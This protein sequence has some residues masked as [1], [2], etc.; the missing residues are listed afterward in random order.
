MCLHDN[1]AAAARKWSENLPS[2]ILPS[3]RVSRLRVS[4][5]R[6]SRLGKSLSSES[7][8]SDLGIFF[9]GRRHHFDLLKDQIFDL[10]NNNTIFRIRN[11]F[12]VNSRSVLTARRTRGL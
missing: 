5:L 11:N 9:R 1:D 4:R 3:E 7:L 12:C 10:D 6:V 2:E 8:P